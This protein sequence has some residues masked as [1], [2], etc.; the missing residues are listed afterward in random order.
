M[1][2]CV[3]V[4]ACVCVRVRVCAFGGGVST[5]YQDEPPEV[6]TRGDMEECLRVTIKYI[7]RYA[8]ARVPT[9][10]P[11]NPGPPP[12]KKENQKNSWSAPRGKKKGKKKD[13][14]ATHLGELCPHGAEIPIVADQDVGLLD[15]AGG[16]GL[17]VDPPD[18]SCLVKLVPSHEPGDRLRGPTK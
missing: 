18:R 2:V 10:P 4:C 13:F 5:K 8:V 14:A 15:P 6:G 11:K 7:L 1:C 16:R 3:R 9:R 12:T 17:A